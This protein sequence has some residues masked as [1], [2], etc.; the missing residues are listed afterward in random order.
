MPERFTAVIAANRFGLGARPGELQSIGAGA[1]EWL[2]AQLSGRAPELADAQLRSSA[3]TLARAL[4]LR[5]EL[6]DLKRETASGADPAASAKAVAALQKVAQVY[7]P[8]YLAEVTARLRQAVSTEQ[9]FL[10]RLTYFWSNHFAV[11]VDKNLVLGLAGSLEREAI[12]PNVLGQFVDMLLTVEQHPA[13][14][15]YLD[16]HV[17]SGPHSAFARS[18]A[19]RNG[20]RPGINENLAREILELHTL[21]VGGGYTQAD[22]TTFAE[23]LTG[24]SISG[25]ASAR[26]FRPDPGKF[27]FRPGLHEPGTKLVLGKHYPDRGLEQGVGVLRDLAASPATAHFIA[28]KLARHFIADEPPAGAVARIAAEFLRTQGNLLAVYRVLIDSPEAWTRPLSKFKSPNDYVVSTFRGL[29]LPVAAGHAALAPFELLGQRTYSPGSPAGWPDRSDDWDG[30]SALLKRVE[31]ADAVG[32]R[33]A[34][35]C[36]ATILAPQLLGEVLTSMTRTAIGHAAS[37]AQA[38]TLLLASPEFM[39]R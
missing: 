38:L 21:G 16:N 2:R 26:I 35:R 28:T 22:V 24:W 3:A 5:R 31:W 17:S 29:Q 19:R 20:R 12:R 23:V 37:A 6:Q 30:A 33:V 34:G 25:G 7:R 13:M 1:R 18:A 32:Q 9:P 15:L 14:L 10:E 39:R 8:V 4:Q 11:S 36:D 27:M